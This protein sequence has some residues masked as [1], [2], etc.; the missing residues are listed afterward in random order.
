MS[1]KENLIS[2]DFIFKEENGEL[3]LVGDFEGYYQS[4]EDPWGQ[5]GADERLQKLYNQSR[6]DLEKA[7]FGLQ[8]IKS[9]NE[10]GCGIGYVTDYLSKKLGDIE[11][12]G[13]DIS[14]TAIEK[15]KN[16]FPK[17]NFF[18]KDICAKDFSSENKYDVIILNQ[19]LWYILEDIDQVFINIDKLLNK[20]G[21]L[22]ISTFFL[23]E[24]RYGADIIGSFDA[25][26]LYCLKKQDYRLINANIK[27]E[28]SQE[29]RDS[30]LVLQ[31]Y[32]KE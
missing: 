22:I 5:S 30:I 32:D 28:D 16:K 12:S 15:A 20:N 27:Y 3:K 13:I 19:I 8:N 11:W 31:K 14:N 29:H 1:N 21:Y 24:Q 18:C 23:K 6:L 10:I 2:K 7:V 9:A 26:I 17:I 25:L 4:E